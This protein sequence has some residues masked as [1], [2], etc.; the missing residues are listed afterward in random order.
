[1]TDNPGDWRLIHPD[2]ETE[3]SW[4]AAQYSESTRTVMN[5]WGT[6]SIE[7]RPGLSDDRLVA[8]I[9]ACE[10]ACGEDLA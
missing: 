9:E 4:F 3:P 5:F 6:I 2:S 8:M 10:Q 7:V 1:M